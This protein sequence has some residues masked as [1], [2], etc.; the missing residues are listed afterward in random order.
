[1]N[2]NPKT[3]TLPLIRE[4]V[5]PFIS[6][7]STLDQLE[8]Q[9]GVNLTSPLPTNEVLAQ[10]NEEMLLSAKAALLKGAIGGEN[11]QEQRLIFEQTIQKYMEIA[12]LS[13]SN[14]EIASS[15]SAIQAKQ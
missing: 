10:D 8:K 11:E 15:T 9:T 1:M 5:T 4:G 6:S 13:Q 7:I 2:S 3:Y 14:R 12:R